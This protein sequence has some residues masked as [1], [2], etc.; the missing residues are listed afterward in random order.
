MSDRDIKAT[1]VKLYVREAIANQR[2]GKT[3]KADRSEP[4]TFELPSA[5]R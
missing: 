4:K 2:R 5:D 3:V 1:R